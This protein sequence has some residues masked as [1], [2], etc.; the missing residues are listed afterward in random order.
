M[1][2]WNGVL[3]YEK[4]CLKSLL[5]FTFLVRYQNTTTITSNMEIV[6]TK[7]GNLF[8]PVPA[9]LSGDGVISGLAGGAET[10]GEGAVPPPGVLKLF[11]GVLVPVWV[12]LVVSPGV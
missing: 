7:A 11:P 9:V 8:F 10:V 4:Y 2:W 1:E 6:S 3:D 12:G 5:K